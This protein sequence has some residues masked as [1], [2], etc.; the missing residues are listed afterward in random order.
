MRDG[1]YFKGIKG[2]KVYKDF[3]D[4]K[5]FKVIKVIKTKKGPHLCG[6]STK[7]IKDTSQ[8][9]GLGIVLCFL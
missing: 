2:F 1:S 8:N 7:T 5:V 3:K 6:P 9:P 4:Y